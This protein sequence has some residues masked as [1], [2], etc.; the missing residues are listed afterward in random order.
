MTSTKKLSLPP[1]I[2]VSRHDK[3][4]V[5]SHINMGEIGGVT[6]S[7]T[8][9]GDTQL[10]P[11][12]TIDT[13]DNKAVIAFIAQ[14]MTDAL[15]M[16][17]AL[18]SPQRSAVRPE[19]L[20]KGVQA[21]ESQLFPCSRCNE[22]IARLI[23]V[24][25]INTARELHEMANKFELEAFVSTYPIW[26]IGAPDSDDDDIAKHLTL[27][28]AP[29]KGD[30]YYEHPDIMNT[31]LIKLDLEHCLGNHKPLQPHKDLH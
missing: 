22:I 9:H 27:Q 16:D 12:L 8:I 26:L 10:Q 14:Q 30:V 28:I 29:A 5:I 13:A 24:T 18:H 4:Y 25:E 3:T 2:T 23:F 6:L 21:I 1:G 20:P 15:I 17:N 31:R 7:E 19:H 11:Y